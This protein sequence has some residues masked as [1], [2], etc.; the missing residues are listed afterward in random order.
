MRQLVLAVVL[1]GCSSEFHARPDAVTDAE[2]G[3]ELGTDNGAGSSLLLLE[4]ES[5]LVGQSASAVVTLVNRGTIE[6][7]PIA[8]AITGPAETDFS[9]SKADSTCGAALPAL[10]RCSLVVRFV[11]TAAGPRNATL[12]FDSAPG[13]SGSLPL[14]GFAT[15][16]AVHFAPTVLD[17]GALQVGGST[18]R[19]FELR[20]DGANSVSL[21]DPVVMGA[22][23][24]QASSTCTATLAAHSSCHISV[25]FGPIAIGQATGFVQVAVDG[26]NFAAPVRVRGARELKVAKTGSGSG[27]I[28]AVAAGIDC[29]ATCRA[30]VTSA[31]TLVATPDAGSTLTG[32][33][34]AS[35][36][37]S[38]TCVVPLDVFAT[39]VTAT[40]VRTEVANITLSFM[41]TGG[42]DAR[43]RTQDG[44]VVANC[45]SSCT[46][47]VM[48]GKPYEIDV[49]TWSTFSGFGG[50]CT[51]TTV[52][53]TCELFATSGSTTVTVALDKRPGERYTRFLP[54][55]PLH[56]KVDTAENLIA[57]LLRTDNSQL[58]KLSPQGEIVWS[59]PFIVDDIDIGP[60]NTIYVAGSQSGFSG[61]FKLDASGEV[62]WKVPIPSGYS[63]GVSGM[64]GFASA[65]AVANDGSAASL[66][67][68]GLVRWDPAGQVTWTKQ[69]A[70]GV[71]GGIGVQ[72]DGT[73][74]VG[75]LAGD[76][77]NRTVVGERFAAA[78]GAQL[79]DLGVVGRE[80]TGQLVVDS[81]G[82][83][84]THNSGSGI[85]VFQWRSH[86]VEAN[87]GAGA[88]A[89]ATGT[90]TTGAGPAIYVNNRS[91]NAGWNLG[92]M[93]PEGSALG[94]V[95]GG[96]FTRFG[97]GTPSLQSVACA[98]TS[99]AYVVGGDYL[100]F[101]A[102][103]IAANSSV[104]YV[105]WIDP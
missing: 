17:I 28:A 39:E 23:F 54:G 29:G 91:D 76:S 55:R 35:C 89:L 2:A 69:V 48:V 95:A 56:M 79:T 74:V 98:K 65:L 81:A 25:V 9:I 47:P 80:S 100:G 93:A 6:T 4:F 38:S 71:V 92:R 20:N 10:G 59:I 45:Y 7:G 62:L 30:L 43:I 105:Q 88:A 13:G 16:P 99:D 50:A 5:A 31:I 1:V 82:Q 103:N 32:W 15:L 40:F 53:G 12:T 18:M 8:F 57:A 22:G 46:V 51:P 73:V 36:G 104:G 96:T 94:T 58:L 3:A 90:C 72:P 24:S 27:R 44:P 102:L 61:L 78:D 11:A 85:T 67:P 87:N 97:F 33:S 83:V 42:G 63:A 68:S 84:A 77:L 34:I 41:G 101:T 52:A 49:S 21:Q 14:S 86:T 70:F 37:A 26:A 19:T 64:S 66:G 60:E 75:R